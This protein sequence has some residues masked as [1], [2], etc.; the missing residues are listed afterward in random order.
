MQDDRLFDEIDDY[1]VSLSVF[2]GPLDLLLTLV[3][4]SELEIYDIPVAEIAT[5]YMKYV[6]KIDNIDLENAGEFMV[7]ATKLLEIKS[8]LVLPRSDKDEDD[9][10]PRLELIQKL[11][12]YKKYRDLGITL[13]DKMLDELSR[14]KRPEGLL[15]TESQRQLNLEEIDV[16]DLYQSFT[17]IIEQVSLE[18]ETIII[19]DIPLVSLMERLHKIIEKEGG[20]NVDFIRCIA[21]I[22]DKVTKIGLFLALLEMVRLQDISA[23]QNDKGT[24]LL[25]LIDNTEV[26][27][28]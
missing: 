13:S 11:L 21:E 26:N 14:Y 9:D 22:S 28:N 16:W 2:S 3:Q 20:Q 12:E 10:D 5:Q 17:E 4:R 19:D 23:S 15:D 18:Y 7:L 27:S 8:T 24:I 1:R 25:S 6:E